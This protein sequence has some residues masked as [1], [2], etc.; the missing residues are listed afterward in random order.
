MPDF[1]RIEPSRT[2]CTPRKKSRSPGRRIIAEAMSSMARSAA[3]RRTP[4]IPFRVDDMVELVTSMSA[5]RESTDAETPRSVEDRDPSR[6]RRFDSST[7]TVSPEA[8]ASLSL[9]A[10]AVN[11]PE[12]RGPSREDISSR[13]SDRRS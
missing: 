3:A 10:G 1:R 2:S 9:E 13:S 5:A 12:A 11:L 4:S 7:S 6:D 8:E